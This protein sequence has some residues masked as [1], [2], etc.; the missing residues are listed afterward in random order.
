[1]SLAPY[2]GMLLEER[3]SRANDV[4]DYVLSDEGRT[5]EEHRFGV[6]RARRRALIAIIRR[7]RLEQEQQQ[8]NYERSQSQT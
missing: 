3:L 2:A 8:I 5:S 1:M 6:S 7:T 4:V